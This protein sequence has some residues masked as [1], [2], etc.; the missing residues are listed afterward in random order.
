MSKS[1]SDVM[2][3][4]APGPEQDVAR[5]ETL[6]LAVVALH[7]HRVRIEKPRPAAHQPDARA[8]QQLVVHPIEPGDLRGTAGPQALPVE[9]HFADVPSEADGLLELFMAMRRMAVQLLRDAA[10]VHASA[11]ERA[12]LGH[13]DPRSPC[14][15]HAAG[16]HAATARTHHEEI[17]I[18]RV[19]GTF[20]Q[21]ATWR[22]VHDA[23]SREPG[24]ARGCG[25]KFAS[26]QA[27]TASIAWRFAGPKSSSWLP[28]GTRRTA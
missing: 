15:G 12:A 25:A 23:S 10:E 3:H 22:L 20:L 6:L 7:T 16:A 2:A 21:A 19:H 18:E 17:A 28:S 1:S 4:S 11:A 9:A 24:H 13:D 27:S 8:R 5:R 14:S 26:S